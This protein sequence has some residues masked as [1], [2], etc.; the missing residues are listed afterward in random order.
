MKKDARRTLSC[1]AS[2]VVALPTQPNPCT[3]PQLAALAVQVLL[4]NVLG[5]I[6]LGH[7]QLRQE[8]GSKGD[9]CQ[10]TYAAISKTA[11]QEHWS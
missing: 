2:Y 10:L 6:P 1:A 3:H 8:R 11:G 9:G 4:E 7:I 5:A